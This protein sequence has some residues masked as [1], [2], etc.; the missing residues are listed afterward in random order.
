MPAKADKTFES[1]LKRLEEIVHSLEES[2]PP[3][4]EALALFEEG[5]SLISLCL[6]KLDEAEQKLKILS[7]P[8][9]D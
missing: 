6:K 2:S 8:E 7:G 3:L 5:K 1:A 4:D 9:E